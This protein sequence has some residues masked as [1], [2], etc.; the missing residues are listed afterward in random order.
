MARS[1]ERYADGDDASQN[2]RL[3]C[4]IRNDANVARRHELAVTQ[5]VGAM[6][7]NDIDG[8]LAALPDIDHDYVRRFRSHVADGGAA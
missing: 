2:G 4:R 8:M 5:L 3:A 6:L 7:A 1:H